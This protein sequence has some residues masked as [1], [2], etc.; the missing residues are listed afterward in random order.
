MKTLCVVSGGD[1]PGINTMLARFSA[2]AA[3]QGDTVTGAVGGFPGLLA[4]EFM[5]LTFDLLMPWAGR[6]GT[7]LPSSREPVLSKPGALEQLRTILA[8]HEVDNLLLFGGDGTLRHIPPLLQSIGARC[9]GIPATI[10]NDVPGT[11]VTVG[12]DSACNFAYQSIDGLMAT[13]HALRGR[14]FMVETLGGN[15][16]ILALAVA[17]GAGAHAVIVPEYEYSEGWLAK[18]L[19][20]AA[21]QFGYSLLV[22]CEG[23]RGARTLAEELPTMT[24][25]RMRDVR[26]GHAQRGGTPTH[27]DRVLAAEMAYAAFSAL[28]GGIG[29]ASLVVRSGQVVLHAGLLPERRML[30]DRALYDRING[31]TDNAN[32]DPRR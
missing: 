27:R 8:R 25:I 20:T 6:A 16:G 14:I 26:L 28:K 30:P 17:H 15:N 21:A 9:L 22:I 24:G 4:E 5:T 7:I 18:R 10:D 23:A 11:E 32:G 3:E 31:L 29:A 1:A 2:L 19:R 12:F 13:A